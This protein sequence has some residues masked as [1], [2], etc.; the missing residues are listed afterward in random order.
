MSISAAHASAFYREVI[1]HQ[2]VWTV[3]DQNG[4]PAPEGSDGHRTMPFWSLLSRAERVITSVPAYRDFE[5]ISLPL[6][7]WMEAWLP[8]LDRDGILVGLNWSGLRA[9]GFEMPPLTVLDS[10][11]SLT[12]DD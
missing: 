4:F 11:N 7:R 2:E 9:T 10:V 1:E 6:K 5:L 8:G 3:R 12:R